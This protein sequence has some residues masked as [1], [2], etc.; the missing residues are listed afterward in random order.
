MK[1]LRFQQLA[2]L[3][4][5]ILA[6]PFIH[7]A[8]GQVNLAVVQIIEPSEVLTSTV[9]VK[10]EFDSAG[11]LYMTGQRVD[12]CLVVAKYATNGSEIWAN[13]YCGSGSPNDRP[14]ALVIDTAG[15]C[16]VSAVSHA[17]NEGY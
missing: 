17:G 1:K 16:Y 10:L 3:I 11:N 7:E 2:T 4:T 12:G 5:C 14:I 13:T 8:L 6:F 15:N 9:P